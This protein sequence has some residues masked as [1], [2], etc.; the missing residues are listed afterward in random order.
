LCETLSMESKDIRTAGELISVAV[1]T[2]QDAVLH[3]RDCSAL[4]RRFKNEAAAIEF[5]GIAAAEGARGQM[6]IDWARAESLE[7]SPGITACQWQEPNVPASYEI[8]AQDPIRSTAYRVLAFA[9][10]RSQ[11]IFR[12]YIDVAAGTKDAK[13]QEYAEILAQEE[14]DFASAMRAKRRRA[15]HAERGQHP[16]ESRIDPRAIETMA[17]LLTVAASLERC[18]LQNLRLLLKTEQQ[19]QLLVKHS[20]NTLHEIKLLARDSGATSEAANQVEE[21]I[22][23]YSSQLTE[24]SLDSSRLLQRLYRDSDRS[25]LYYD[26]VV[27]RAPE[28]AILL[29]AQR[30]TYLALLRLN[31][32]HELQP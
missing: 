16:H 27:S 32:L 1:H 5:D 11:Q 10:Q 15:W 22:E 28:E 23:D 19:V 24:Q 4:M 12:F 18:I 3:Y 25:F 26:F 29:R 9:T 20:E 8:E 13:I 17:D 31:M 2:S 6:M 21:V 14:L 30:L 7:L